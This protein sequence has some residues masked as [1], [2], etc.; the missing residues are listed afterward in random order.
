MI[1]SNVTGSTPTDPYWDNV[2]LLLK[3]IG[4]GDVI[5]SFVDQS[6]KQRIIRRTGGSDGTVVSDPAYPIFGHSSFKSTQQTSAAYISTSDPGSLTSDLGA[7]GTGDFTV[8]AWIYLV[9]TPGASTTYGICGQTGAISW[10]VNIISGGYLTVGRNGTTILTSNVA[11]TTGVWHHVA[12][13]RSSG[14]SALYQDG[15]RTVTTTDTASWT[16]S[17]TNNFGIGGNNTGTS[18]ATTAT[19]SGF[20]IGRI[21][22]LRITN[23]VA[24]YTGTSYAVPTAS[25]PTAPVTTLVLRGESSVVDGG[26]RRVPM[27]GTNS[28]GSP[29]FGTNSFSF[30]GSQY[31]Y[32]ATGYAGG[33]DVFVEDGTVEC[34]ALFTSTASSPHVFEIGYDLNNRYGVYLNSGKLTFFSIQA[35]WPSN[36]FA[37]LGPAA[38]I[39]TWY[40]IAAIKKGSVY[41][42]FVNGVLYGS[43][44]RTPP[45]FLGSGSVYIGYQPFSGGSYDYL[46]GRVDD[47]RLTMNKAIYT[48][49]FVPPSV[50]VSNQVS[51]QTDLYWGNVGLLCHFND[52]YDNGIYNRTITSVGSAVVSTAQKKF[53]AASLLL[54]GTSQYVSVGP[55]NASI[56]DL[57]NQTAFTV[58]AWVYL[59]GNSPANGASLCRATIIDGGSQSG[60]NPS[61]WN[62]SIDGDGTTT[63]TGLYFE[64]KDSS[65]TSYSASCSVSISTAGWHHVAVVRNGA[66]ITFYLDG[67]AQTTASNTIGNTTFAMGAQLMYIGGRPLTSYQ[68][69]LKG[70]IDEVRITN[71]VARSITLPTAAF[72]DGNGS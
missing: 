27:I 61:S 18:T 13:V 8:E 41:S 34:W 48:E 4:A 37:I 71:N 40:H 44:T 54:N 36:N 55:T 60:S 23:G 53:G 39:N 16:F 2:T 43:A 45:P 66:T 51:T 35:N 69:F 14:V 19:G 70:Y 56:N 72:P 38:S 49:S 28:Y 67:V 65:S 5:S 32:S 1:F 52:L 68:Q 50:Q 31:Q 9:T 63:G 3:F 7:F 24:R 20:S 57:C 46:Q 59:T 11:L 30:S 6:K 22:E 64:M 10:I 62:F 25:F 58:E 17:T 26:A 15:V 29:K 42:L 33:N 12:V 47:F 21:G